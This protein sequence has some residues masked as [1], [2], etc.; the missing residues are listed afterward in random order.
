MD[1]DIIICLLSLVGTLSGTFCGI[2]T[3]SRLTAYRIQKLEEKVDMHNKFAERIPLMEE[4]MNLLDKRLETLER[5]G[6]S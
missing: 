4:K 1:N 5:E 6:K 2:I 3:S